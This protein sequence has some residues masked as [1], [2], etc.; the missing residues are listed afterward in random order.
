MPLEVQFNLEFGDRGDDS[1][2]VEA[3]LYVS[4]GGQSTEGFV[5]G[6]LSKKLIHVPHVMERWEALLRDTVDAFLRRIG[7]IKQGPMKSGPSNN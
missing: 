7:T 4:Q 1:D 5:V 6:T 2:M 3:I